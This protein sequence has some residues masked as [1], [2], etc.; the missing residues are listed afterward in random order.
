MVKD[1]CFYLGHISRKHGY[2]G[3]VVAVFDTDQPEKY[4]ELESVFVDSHGEL[5]PFFIE[6]LATNSKGHFILRFEDVDSDQEAEKMVGRELYLP[7]AVLPPL[8][9]K[10]F[11][12][13]EVVDFEVID[14]K[15]GSIG[16]VQEVVD[17]SAQ[18]IFKI[19]DG[20]TEIL[21]PAVDDFI[22][23]IDRD[24]KQIHLATPEGLI[25]LYRH[26]D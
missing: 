18:P 10:A 1:D 15:A 4:R 3:E 2:K 14:A 23:S 8:S 21:I 11:Y 13:H 20:D 17:S 7:L 25:E 12:F 24:K 6:E 26:A 9:G 16:R 19:M 5:I 22:V